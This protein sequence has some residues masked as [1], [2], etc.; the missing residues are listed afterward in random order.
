MTVI[1]CYT[2]TMS[3]LSV[4]SQGFLWCI[5]VALLCTIAVHGF[6]LAVLGYR[7]LRRKPPPEPPKPPEKVP[8]PVYF[9]VERK[10]KRSKAEY[11]E[12]KQINFQ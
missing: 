1:H 11:S 8:E 12:P 3:L 9:L 5:L 6:K 2:E 7:S 4:Q 10:K